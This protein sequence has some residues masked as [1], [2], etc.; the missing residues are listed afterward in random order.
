MAM[1]TKYNHKEVEQGKNQKWIDK[2]FF[3]QRSEKNKPYSI[4]L[5]PPNVTGKLHLGHAWDGFIQDTLIRFKKLQGYD[6]MFVPGLDHAGIATQ[7]K[8]EAKLKKEF[9]LT[10]YDMGR[11]K[12]LDKVWEWKEEYA[13]A[14]RDQ[15]AQ[16]GLALDYTKE[17]FTMDEGLSNA[18]TKVFI[19]MY[20]DKL[21][22]RGERP[23]NWDPALQTVL[24]NIEVIP[25]QTNSVMYYFNYEMLDGGFI[26]VATTR[27]E[28]MFSDVAIAVNPNDESMKHFIGKTA[29]S[30]LTKQSLPIIGDHYIEIN[31]GTGAMKVSA[32]AEADFNI[33]KANNLETK[34]CIDKQGKMNELAGDLKGMDRFEARKAVVKRLAKS[35]CK[36]EEIVNS[37]GHSER[38]NVPIETLVQPQWFVKMKPLAKKLLDNLGSEN[39]VKFYPE[40]FE[41]T[42]KTWM[43]EIQD[44][45]ISRQLWWGH[46]I[47]AWY[48][49]EEIKVQVDCPGEGWVQDE[50]VLDT[51]F[52]SGLAPF[53]FIG[54]PDDLELLKRFYPTSVL[55]TGYDIIFFWV[56]R[57][58]FQGLEF[59]CQRPFERVLIHGLIRAEDGRK[60][61]KSLGNGIDPMYV[62][63]KFGSDALRY[64]VMTNS[65]PGQD[66]RYSEQKI[67]AAWALNNK[68]WNISRYILEIMPETKSEITDADKWI[69]V[70]LNTL[71]KLI[72]QKMDSY[73]FTIIGKELTKFVMEDFSSWY[74][75]FTKATPNKEVAQDILQKLLIIMHPFMPFITDHLFNLI[76]SKELLDQKWPLETFV[77]DTDYIDRVIIVVK[78][79]RNFRTDKNIP[80]SVA[81][82]YWP[83]IAISGEED[84]MIQKLANASI[85]KNDDALVALG[86]FNIYIKLSDELKKNEDERIVKEISFLKSEIARAQSMLANERFVSKAP[87]AKISEEKAK[88][89]NFQARLQEIISIK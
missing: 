40:R 60:M 15:W 61:S 34:E 53:S 74:I 23:V 18:V 89:E 70:K 84:S 79:I 28:T 73:D 58:Y 16:L 3:S 55:V 49:G 38:S 13:Q 35:L 45:C 48:K 50:D 43:E 80:N 72:E 9:H 69:I 1:S 5:P 81:L 47:P 37:V 4:I 68:L 19:K 24:S 64:F 67:E 52:S 57:M 65:T 54:W 14:I 78:A 86:D 77:S 39:G 33:I 41:D 10:R 46:R 59:M 51:W 85:F 83:S 63:D 17:R 66:I 88:L 31:K 22:Y 29:I 12:F 6:V 87:V 42:I 2:K 62:I 75:E 36:T 30:P 20:Q 44:W 26:Q 21:I 7:A 32:H 25:T 56:A 71:S 8:V 76:D 11:E 27:P 82:N